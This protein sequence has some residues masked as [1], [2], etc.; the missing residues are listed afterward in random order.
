MKRNS[1][2]DNK[3]ATFIR[4]LD[5]DPR[6]GRTLARI[7]PVLLSPL[8]LFFYLKYF[9]PLEDILYLQDLHYIVFN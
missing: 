2:R 9:L 5:K 4:A 7:P 8:P 1:S 3:V 6:I